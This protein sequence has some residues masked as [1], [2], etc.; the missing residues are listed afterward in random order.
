MRIYLDVPI[1]EYKEALNLGAKLDKYMKMF[2]YKIDL[3]KFIKKLN[4]NLL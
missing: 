1:N 2:V 3:N 4:G